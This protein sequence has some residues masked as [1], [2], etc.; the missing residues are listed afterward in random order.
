MAR[1]GTVMSTPRQATVAIQDQMVRYWTSSPFL[2]AISRLQLARRYQNQYDRL[3]A[4]F[5]NLCGCHSWLPTFNSEVFKP[6]SCVGARQGCMQVRSCSNILD[7]Y[8]SSAARHRTHLAAG[9]RQAGASGLQSR[10]VS[11]KT[12]RHMPEPCLRS[13]ASSLTRVRTGSLLRQ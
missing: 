4:E 11:E 7:G 3:D 6:N 1:A 10:R 9:M 5:A 8:C 2:S 13:G 12:Q